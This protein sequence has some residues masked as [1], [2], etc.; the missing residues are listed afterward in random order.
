MG[1]LHVIHYIQHNR[2]VATVDHGKVGCLKRYYLMIM[3]SL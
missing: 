3:C 1:A 2:P